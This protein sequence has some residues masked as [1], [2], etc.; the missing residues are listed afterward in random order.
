MDATPRGSGAYLALGLALTG[1]PGVNL[2]AD[3]R[4]MGVP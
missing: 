3:E 1:I 2:H 4:R